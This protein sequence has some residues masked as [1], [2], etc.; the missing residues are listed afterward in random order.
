M[1]TTSCSGRTSFCSSHT[2]LDLPMLHSKQF[3]VLQ[4]SIELGPVCCQI[5]TYCLKV[6]IFGKQ[7]SIWSHLFLCLTGDKEYHTIW[8]TCISPLADFTT[9]YSEKR[10]VYWSITETQNI[11]VKHAT[12]TLE[13]SCLKISLIYATVQRSGEVVH[14]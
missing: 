6:W 2:L 9:D 3:F 5:N 12:V 7:D 13:V 1:S 4:I 11:A 14:E 10:K 8:L